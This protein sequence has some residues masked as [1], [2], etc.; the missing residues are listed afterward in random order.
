[1][2]NKELKINAVICDARKTSEEL[3]KLYESIAINAVMVLVSK[4]SKDLFA[5]YNVKI[6]ASNIFEASKDAE[7]IT[8][9]GYFEISGNT[10]MS[11]STLLIVNGHLDIKQDAVDALKSFDAIIVNGSVSYPSS[12]QNLLP[13]IKINGTIDSYPSDAIRLKH[14]HIVDKTFLLIAKNA[15]YY[16][17]NEVVIA[18][19]SLDLSSL[20]EKGTFFITKKA[21]IAE[22]LLDSAINLFGD[23]TDITVIPAGYKY[24]QEEYL[25]NYVINKYGDKLYVDGDLVITSDN[26]DALHKLTG[27][28]VNGSIMISNNLVDYLTSIDAEYEDLEIIKGIIIEDRGMINISK[29]TLA[30]YKYGVTISDCGKVELSPDITPEEI[31]EKL[32]FIDCGYILCSPE[33]KGSVEMVSEDVGY[34]DD[35]SEPHIMNSEEDVSGISDKNTHVIK[36]VFYSL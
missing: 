35:R 34:V 27:L 8:Y 21:I 32:M 36:T 30:R 18:D 1:M 13:P 17:K 33:Q 7:I 19:E 16:A 15:K 22:K 24:V 10:K 9:N 26:E 31:E 20:N 2:E 11:N 6:N 23:D 5:R 25:N 29:E 3:L 14:R 28:K 4:E 12:I